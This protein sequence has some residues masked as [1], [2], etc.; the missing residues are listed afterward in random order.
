MIPADDLDLAPEID[1]AETTG[2]A[3]VPHAGD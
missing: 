3:Q 2:A 1:P